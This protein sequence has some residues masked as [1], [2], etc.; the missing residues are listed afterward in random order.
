MIQCSALGKFF[1]VLRN[2]LRGVNLM[3]HSWTDVSS[4]ITEISDGYSVLTEL[5]G[6]VEL[7]RKMVKTGQVTRWIFRRILFTRRFMR[8]AERDPSLWQTRRLWFVKNWGRILFPFT[9]HQRCKLEVDDRGKIIIINHP[10]LT[11]PLVTIIWAVLNFPDKPV[12]LPVNLPWFEEIGLF[13]GPLKKIGIILL[14]MLTPKTIKRLEEHQT[15]A[16]ME[17]L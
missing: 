17:L 2:T 13:L 6:G 15:V 11:D 3:D 9:K 14:P 4:L 10:S 7:K 8:A 5:T 16:G 1:K 12:L